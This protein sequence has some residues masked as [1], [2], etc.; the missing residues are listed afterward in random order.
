MIK[1]FR[2]AVFPEKTHQHGWNEV[3][4]LMRTHLH[5]NTG[6]P[7]FLDDFL[8]ISFGDNIGDQGIPYKHWW[9]G[10]IHHP[11]RIPAGDP[12]LA[13]KSADTWMRTTE[14]KASLPRCRGLITFSQSNAREIRSILAEIGFVIP[15]FTLAHPTEHNV[16][17]FDFAAFEK[18]RHVNCVGFWLRRLQTFAHLNTG[19][20]KR[21]ILMSHRAE[22]RLAHLEKCNQGLKKDYAVV[23]YLDYAAYNEALASGVGFADYIACNASNTVLEHLARATP[24]VVNPHPAIVDYL[25]C[26]YPLYYGCLAEAEN[27][28]RDT[29]TLRQGHEYLKLRAQSPATRYDW[30][31]SA[32][33]DVLQ[34]VL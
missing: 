25:G 34:K 22:E 19:L 16:P 6:A 20:K 5:Q 2:E 33:R 8:D 31:I 14:F 13:M 1:I 4:R 28:L 18:T 12:I 32:L 7:A 23:P 10:M 17:Q 15:V 29:K 11:A 30:F 3:L 21:Y 26:D 24:L 9:V 27:I